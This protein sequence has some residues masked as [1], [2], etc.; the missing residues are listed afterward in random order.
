MYY[1]F[2]DSARVLL[3]GP[4]GI[5][6]TV[7]QISGTSVLNGANSP[8]DWKRRHCMIGKAPRHDYY[9]NRRACRSGLFFLRGRYC[10]YHCKYPVCYKRCICT[11]L[12]SWYLC[13]PG[14]AFPDGKKW[15]ITIGRI[16][17]GYSIWQAA[18]GKPLPKAI[19]ERPA[20]WSADSRYIAYNRLDVYCS[21]TIC[22]AAGSGELAAEPICVGRR[23]GQLSLYPH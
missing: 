19:T 12:R 5:Y 11:F 23:A 9:M 6:Y 2:E 21:S 3:E 10:L 14:A 8:A 1:A 13:R 22:K 15:F 16:N 20:F 17:C 7:S 4:G 18:A